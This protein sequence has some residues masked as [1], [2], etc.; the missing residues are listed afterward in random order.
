MQLREKIAFQGSDIEPMPSR[1]Y[2]TLQGDHIRISRT[3]TSSTAVSLID[4]IK[5]PPTPPTAALVLNFATPT[6]TEKNSVPSPIGARDHELDVEQKHI[7]CPSTSPRRPQYCFEDS[8]DDEPSP[9]AP[10]PKLRRSEPPCRPPPLE[11]DVRPYQASRLGDFLGDESRLG[12]PSRA[13]SISSYYY[14]KENE[15]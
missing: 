15:L 8:D 4:E 7:P 2:H 3:S 5:P 11:L 14:S 13:Y 9:P 10:P 1:A 6:N 12:A